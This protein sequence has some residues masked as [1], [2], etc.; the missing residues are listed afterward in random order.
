MKNKLFEIKDEKLTI[1]GSKAI[2]SFKAK[3]DIGWAKEIQYI[4]IQRIVDRILNDSM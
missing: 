2:L 1:E 4:K 3:G